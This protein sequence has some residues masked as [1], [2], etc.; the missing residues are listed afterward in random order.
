M[1]SYSSDLKKFHKEYK[2]K[3]KKEKIQSQLQ[4]EKEEQ[5]KRDMY[6]AEIREEKQNAINTEK[7]IEE[8]RI[9]NIE[10]MQSIGQS[11]PYKI[12]LL[13]RDVINNQYW[14]VI[15][16]LNRNK[17]TLNDINNAIE[18]LLTENMITIEESK[19]LNDMV[20]NDIK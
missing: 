20:L 7:Q 18:F 14:Q 8:K 4:R 5:F 12:W 3:M 6:F 9:K 16:D 10:F 2:I 19:L 13:Y 17:I 15:D 1:S 11:V